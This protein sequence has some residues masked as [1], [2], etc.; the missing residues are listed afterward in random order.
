MRRATGWAMAALLLMPATAAAQD[1]GWPTP[2]ELRQELAD[3]GWEWAA[4]HGLWVG[5]RGRQAVN[6]SITPPLYVHVYDVTL[7]GSALLSWE[8]QQAM[9]WTAFMELAERL[10]IDAETLRAINGQ[11]T[12]GACRDY[13]LPGGMLTFDARSVESGSIVIVEG[14]EPRC[15]I[16]PVESMAP[17]LVSPDES[18]AL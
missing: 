4:N 10:P 12:D 7:L 6:M 2:S 18:P 8:E 11:L 1:D 14:G 13:A 16:E 17:E 3:D 9:G 15:D 5:G